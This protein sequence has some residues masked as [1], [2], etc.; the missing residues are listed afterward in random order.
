M[1]RIA[2]A[3]ALA[4]AGCGTNPTQSP[5]EAFTLDSVD[6]AFDGNS[7]GLA[8][9]DEPV[10]VQGCT[11][12]S[13]R[14]TYFQANYAIDG[15]LHSAWA[16]AADDTAPSLVLQLPTV[17][18]LTRVSLKQSHTNVTVDVAVSRAGGAWSTVATGLAPVATTLSDLD[19]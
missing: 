9:T 3:L 10:T 4:L 14:N 18:R 13:T 6:Y 19:L 5:T 1:K 16:P 15:N 12:S 8:A 7:Y 17:Q 2:F 11:A